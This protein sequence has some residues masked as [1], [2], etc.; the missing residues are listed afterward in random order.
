[1]HIVHVHVHVKPDYIEAFAQAA[2]E[3]A[4]NSVQ[5]PGIAPL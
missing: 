2:L 1:M 4:R 3:N 5:E